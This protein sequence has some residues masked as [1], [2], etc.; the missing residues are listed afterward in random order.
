MNRVCII[1]GKGN[2]TVP[3]NWTNIVS[4]GINRLIYISGGKG[5][6][7]ENNTLRPFEVGKL[8]L[9]PYYANAYTYTQD[10]DRLV[11]AFANFQI[12]PPI[13]SKK[14]FCLD[15]SA[16]P[17]LKA[18][19]ELFSELTK[20]WYFV[21]RQQQALEESEKQELELLKA[22]VIYFVETMIN[23]Q[24]DYIVNNP[25]VISALEMIHSS[26]AQGLTVRDI[27]ARCY[28][29]YEGFIRTFTYY[30]GETP[31]SYMK[32]IKIGRALE[33]RAQGATT[34]E[35]AIA[36]GYSSA[37]AMLHSLS[38]F[39]EKIKKQNI[40]NKLLGQDRVP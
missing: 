7:L 20:K 5:E 33:L 32:K 23:S 2:L 26:L 11:H 25:T 1:H 39:Y 19:L 9:L 35:A 21:H 37:S 16:S 24:P 4:N 38:S 15:P 28:M 14:V 27:A 34:E 6:Y 17:S 36:C 10:E 8:Y 3:Q 40:V 12:S 18:A 29:S 13:I 22:L 30:V 31:Y